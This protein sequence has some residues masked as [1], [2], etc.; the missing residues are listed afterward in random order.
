MELLKERILKDGS[1]KPGNV[2]KVD[3]FLNHQMDIS[4]INE[5]GKEFKR[6]FADRPITKILTI[7]AS[8]IG[9][10]C[11]TAQ[12]FNVPVV[13]AKKTESIN[14]DGDVY[15]T[16]VES[17]THKKTYNVI[18][19]KK[20]L[21][22]EDHVLLIDDFLANGCALLGLIDIV[23]E[24]GAVLEGAGI[25]IEKGFQTGGQKI[26]E[27]GIHLESLAIIDS[28]SDTSLTFR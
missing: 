24:S 23:N 19:S 20:Y 21:G 15:R 1:V 6:L 18:L 5:I 26:R 11:I 9:I 4:L 3:S 22:P 2:L 27:M 13:F 16:N 25:V 8:G 7:E 10:A 12:Y 28:M 17:F 14:L